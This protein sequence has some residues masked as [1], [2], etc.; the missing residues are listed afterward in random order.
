MDLL[1]PA[2]YK[3]LKRLYR[4]Q[5]GHIL[6]ENREFECL[7]K[8]QLI[9]SMLFP[10]ESIEAGT[11]ADAQL[12][13]RISEKG[14]EYVLK[15]RSETRRKW[16]PVIISAAISTIAVIISIIALVRQY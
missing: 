13:W 14:I 8:A 9:D 6:E 1:D 15:H 4:K 7:Y 12:Q 2:S 11:N 16:V 3:I 5:T 10:R